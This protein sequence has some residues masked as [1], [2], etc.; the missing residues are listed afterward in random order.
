MVERV[1]VT[2]TCDDSFYDIELPANIQV[3][4]LKP[5]MAAAMLKKGIRLAD[6]FHLKYKG[7]LL[8]DTDTLFEA[9][10]WDGSYLL[11]V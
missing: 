2:L 1:I 6:G 5:L 7:T 8:N 9:G 11:V 4:Q 10:V 3:F